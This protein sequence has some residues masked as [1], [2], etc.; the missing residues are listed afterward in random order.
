MSL[1]FCSPKHKQQYHHQETAIYQEKVTKIES[2]LTSISSQLDAVMKKAKGPMVWESFSKESQGIA[3]REYEALKKIQQIKP[4]T[5]AH[6]EQRLT[7][8]GLELN[9]SGKDCFLFI[10]P[11]PMNNM[12]IKDDQ[13]FYIADINKEKILSK[14]LIK[15]K[16]LSIFVSSLQI[17][18]VTEHDHYSY[19]CLRSN[20]SSYS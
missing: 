20:V 6:P 13:L 19:L 1:V 8:Q 12:F 10:S 2:T 7:R 18:T 3:E 16:D 15:G 9:W 11:S 5:L 14:R 17:C 4:E